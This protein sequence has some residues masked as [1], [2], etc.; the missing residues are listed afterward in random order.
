[1][2]KLEA[3]VIGCGVSGLTCGVRLLEAGY[4]TTIVARDLP[5]DTTSNVAAAIW[6]PYKAYPAARV[7]AWGQRSFEVFSELLNTPGTGVSLVEA[8][9]LWRDPTPDP[10]WRSAVRR[11][12]R[13]LPEE[14][15]ADYADGYIFETPVI[16]MDI[17]LDYLL[18]RFR[19]LGG[20]IVQRELSSL[21]EAFQLSPLVINCTGL[22]ARDLVGD[23]TLFPIRG[24]VVRVTKPDISRAYLDD[25]ERHGLT[26]IVPRSSD[27]IL[28]GTAQIGDWS[29]EPDLRE[30]EAII[31]RCARLVPDV[32]DVE[33]LEHKIGL[34]PGR[35]VVRLRAEQLPGGTVIH[36]YGHGGA[37]VTLSWGCAEE[38]VGLAQAAERQGLYAK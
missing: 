16:E 2:K 22:G 12:R 32:R 35:P 37:G 24:R 10:W 11:F 23:A 13:A 29:L 34:R 38:V 9:E 18:T 21:D 36:D 15:P 3:T 28:G 1:M 31:E 26:Y 20:E 7:T 19:S 8:F 17:Y 27:C 5:P 33:I 14:L 4:S 6:E 30:A 25:D